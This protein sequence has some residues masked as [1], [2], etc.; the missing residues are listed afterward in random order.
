M[1]P[2]ATA[3]P[4]WSKSLCAERGV[5]AR[6]P[7]RPRP[8]RGQPSWERILG[9]FNRYDGGPT[10]G[11]VMGAL[12]SEVF[13]FGDQGSRY[14]FDPHLPGAQEGRKVW[15]PTVTLQKW[16]LIYLKTRATLNSYCVKQFMERT[17]KTG[18]E[19]LL[20]KYI[21]LTLWFNSASFYFIYSLSVSW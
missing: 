18:V 6:P 15:L 8:C 17:L 20:K 13:L 1:C 19:F 12:L 21:L 3:S 16:H 14:A 7:W 10:P 4:F 11:T 9:T 5:H 2:S